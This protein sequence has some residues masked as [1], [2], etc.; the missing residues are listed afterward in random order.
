[1]ILR[2]FN[3]PLFYNNEFQEY[4]KREETL[5]YYYNLIAN[6]IDYF[7]DKISFRLLPKQYRESDS[8][9][10]CLETTENIMIFETLY[11]NL[12]FLNEE[13]KIINSEDLVPGTK[14]YNIKQNTSEVLSFQRLQNFNNKNS[15]K[16][17]GFYL[18]DG[19]GVIINGLHLQ[20]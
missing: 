4:K 1:M 14:L 13:K 7:T 18:P 2:F 8:S 16:N 3:K 20:N 9:V 19:K 15:L 10:W 17:Y 12:R 5:G 11:G 6:K